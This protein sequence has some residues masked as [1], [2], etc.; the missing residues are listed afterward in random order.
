[1]RLTAIHDI[2]GRIST[3][4]TQPPDAPPGY[5]EVQGEQLKTELAGTELNF[6]LRI[7]SC[8]MDWLNSFRRFLSKQEHIVWL[9]VVVYSPSSG[10]V[11]RQFM[12]SYRTA[13]CWGCLGGL[14][15]R[16][17]TQPAAAAAA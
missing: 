7:S 12:M 17:R 16:G 9:S 5:V 1:M 10:G 8:R 4:F 15:V 3:L 6:D 2:E 11:I 13:L 14:R